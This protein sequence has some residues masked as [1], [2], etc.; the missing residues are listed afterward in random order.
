MIDFNKFKNKYIICD[1]IKIPLSDIAEY[2]LYKS[3]MY[4][5][6]SDINLTTFEYMRK[7]LHQKLFSFANKDRI[8]DRD[9][10][11]SI[12]LAYIITDIFSCPIH[13]ISLDRDLK[14]KKCDFKLS[15]YTDVINNISL[16][17]EIINGK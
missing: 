4:F 2:V 16:N 3:K 1:G 8:K 11:F 7:K 15:S 9:S 5:N 10:K 17:L 13:L 6:T 14:C 12:E